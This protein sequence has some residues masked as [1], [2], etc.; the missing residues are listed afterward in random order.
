[1]TTQELYDNCKKELNDIL[2]TGDP[3]AFYWSAENTVFN[4]ACSQH[5]IKYNINWIDMCDIFKTEPIT[6]KGC[7]GF[8]LKEI[9][10]NMNKH[11]MINTRIESECNNG[12]IAMVKAWRCYKTANNP[13]HSPI[14]KDIEKYN[15]FDCKVLFDILNFLRYKYKID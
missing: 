10:K 4:K 12:M 3:P 15:E 1:M 14:M 5:N 6:I 13:I 11:N 8:G 7:F 2:D 9:S